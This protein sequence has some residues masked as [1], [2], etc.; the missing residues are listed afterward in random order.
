[1]KGKN[2]MIIMNKI[3]HRRYVAALKYIFIATSLIAALIIVIQ[4]GKNKMLNAPLLPQE[5]MKEEKKQELINEIINICNANKS[6]IYCD[7]YQLTDMIK[8]TFKIYD[9]E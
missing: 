1:M 4:K 7:K 9:I 3:I 8:E 5:K 2:K 6:N